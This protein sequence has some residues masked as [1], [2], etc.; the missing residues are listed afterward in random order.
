M[1]SKESNKLFESWGS[2]IDSR[3]F[4]CSFCGADSSATKGWLM[5]VRHRSNMRN[6]MM[7]YIRS[8]HVCQRCFQPTYINEDGKQFPSMKFG[9][10]I[11][12][13]PKEI[14]SLYEEARRGM[15]A[16]NHASVAMCCRVLLMHIAVDLGA[17]KNKKYAWYIQWLLDDHHVP[18]KWKSWVDKI[19]NVGNEV[20]HE[21]PQISEEDAEMVL[22][23]TEA[24]LRIL[25]EYSAIAA[26]HDSD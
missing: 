5:S 14:N 26:N 6:E 25:F 11:P 4:I 20:N 15:G 7:G 10:S 2:D 18:V 8:I 9:T 16:G 21:I 19:K 12:H 22:K 23:F 13:L 1:L 17:D 3:P 24:L